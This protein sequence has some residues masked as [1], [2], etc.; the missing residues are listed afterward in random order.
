MRKRGSEPRFRAPF[1]IRRALVPC[2]LLRLGAFP[3]RGRGPMRAWVLKSRPQGMP[4]PSD[5][6]LLTLPDQPL[7]DGQIRVRNLWLSVDPYMR[8]RMN[9][10]KSYV[11]PFA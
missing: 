11:P 2:R 7:G 6:A 4:Q 5:F 8:G 9:D 1:L 10:A 3:Q